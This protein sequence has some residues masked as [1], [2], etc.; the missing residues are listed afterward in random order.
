MSSPVPFQ[1]IHQVKTQLEAHTYS[2]FVGVNAALDQSTEK[3]Q[4]CFSSPFYKCT[5]LADINHLE[6]DAA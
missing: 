3:Q 5:S 2:S 1:N 4:L 6:A